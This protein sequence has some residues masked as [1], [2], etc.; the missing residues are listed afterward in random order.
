MFMMKC[1]AQRLR[2]LQFM[3]PR[4]RKSG[5]SGSPFSPTSE[6]RCPRCSTVVSWCGS[7]LTVAVWCRRSRMCLGAKFA[8]CTRPTTTR[9]RRRSRSCRRSCHHNCCGHACVPFIS[10]DFMTSAVDGPGGALEQGH[11]GKR[12]GQGQGQAPSVTVQA[13]TLVNPIQRDRG[14]GWPTQRFDCSSAGHQLA[15]SSLIAAAPQ[16]IC[17]LCRA[18]MSAWVVALLQTYVLRA[19]LRFDICALFSP[20]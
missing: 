9:L 18:D 5:F 2:G 19:S 4:T 20:E 11:G 6:D 14:L 17:L 12:Q 13:H 3:T 10:R 1:G 8:D 16:S 7:C 15:A